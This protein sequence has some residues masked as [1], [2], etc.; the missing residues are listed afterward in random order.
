MVIEWFSEAANSVLDEPANPLIEDL[1]EEGALSVVYGESGGGKSFGILD[2]GFHVGAG[3]G[4]NEKK[5]KRGLVVYVAAEGGKRIKRR[6]AALKI[7][8][9]KEYG[10]TPPSRCSPYQHP[11]APLRI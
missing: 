3:L 10:R 11:A 1:L 6:I 9:H 2:M 7:R 4:W 8:Y 5:V